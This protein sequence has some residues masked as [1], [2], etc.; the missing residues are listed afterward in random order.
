MAAQL[1]M[2]SARVAN[3]RNMTDVPVIYHYTDPKGLIGI[4]THGQ[5]WATDIRYLNDSS[6]LRHAEELQR[7]VL[8]ELLTESPD[9]SLKKRLATEALEAPPSFK[10]SENTHVVCFCA[11]DDLLTQ[12]KT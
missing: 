4:L 7:K 1:Q 8:G 3:S 12:W 5:L 9:R 2:S 10:G 11:E 6:E